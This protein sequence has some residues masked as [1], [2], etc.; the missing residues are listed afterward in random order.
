MFIIASDIDSFCLASNGSCS[1][2]ILLLFTVLLTIFM[3]VA[4]LV[5]TAALAILCRLPLLA[6]EVVANQVSQSKTALRWITNSCVQ[7]TCYKLLKTLVD[8]VQYKGG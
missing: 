7:T 5:L 3:L 6:L 4:V 8:V 1:C 2:V